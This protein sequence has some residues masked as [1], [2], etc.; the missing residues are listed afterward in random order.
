MLPA[1]D[2]LR[3]LSVD[4]LTGLSWHLLGPT[5]QTASPVVVVALDEETYRPLH[6]PVVRT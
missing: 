3:G 1:M 2:V 4:A 5:R 6:L